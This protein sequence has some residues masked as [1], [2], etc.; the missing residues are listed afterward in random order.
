MQIEAAVYFV[1]RNVQKLNKLKKN[2]IKIAKVVI[3]S[4]GTRIE[5][6]LGEIETN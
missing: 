1:G 4:K 3:I 5:I 6:R 2:L